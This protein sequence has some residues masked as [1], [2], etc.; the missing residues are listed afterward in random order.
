MNN[1]RSGLRFVVVLL[2]KTAIFFLICDI[3][4]LCSV[5]A[6]QK[7]KKT[8]PMPFFCVKPRNPKENL[9]FCVSQIGFEFFSVGQGAFWPCGGGELP[10]HN[11]DVISVDIPMDT[12]RFKSSGSAEIF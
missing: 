6:K 8:L 2:E 7:N 5:L 10:L 4:I 12:P 3:F 9:R 1:T 11:N